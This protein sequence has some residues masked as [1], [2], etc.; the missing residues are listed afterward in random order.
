MLVDVALDVELRIGCDDR[1]QLVGDGVGEGL[2][3]RRV[4]RALPPDL[5]GDRL[6][7]Q[8]HGDA[9][10]EADDASPVETV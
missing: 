9:G 10:A 6:H 2:H 8:R 1:A 7:E 5:D 3:L 4:R